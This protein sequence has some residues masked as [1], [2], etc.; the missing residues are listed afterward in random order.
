MV[1]EALKAA[2]ILERQGVQCEVVDVR[3][4]YPCDFATMTESVKKTGQALVL[5]YDWVFC[6]FGAEI[7]AQ[8]H[9]QC[10]GILK[11]P[12]KRFGFAAAPCPTTRPLENIYYPSAPQIIREVESVFGLKPLD[13]SQE[14]FYSYEKKFKG[15]F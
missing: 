7:A 12:I 8:L 13:L 11:R 5:D 6:G 2:E 15:P 4:I 14:Q 3:S 10:F 9:E 1:I